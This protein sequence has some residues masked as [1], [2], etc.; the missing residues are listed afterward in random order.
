MISHH[1]DGEQQERNISHFNI[2]SLGDSC[3]LFSQLIEYL[4]ACSSP[5]R[6]GKLVSCPDRQPPLCGDMKILV[7]KKI[8]PCAE[9]ELGIS[10][11]LFC[12]CRV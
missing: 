2:Y 6:F 1:I 5:I 8:L 12:N 10:F 11:F 4:L 3:S 7:T 9:Y